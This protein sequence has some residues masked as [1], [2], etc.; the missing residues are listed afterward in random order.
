[1][2]IVDDIEK[3]TRRLVNAGIGAY[4]TVEEKFEGFKADVE[5]T[6][7]EWEKGFEDLVVKGAADDSDEARNIRSKLDE[8][9]TAVRKFQE[10]TS[11][12]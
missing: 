8:G 5:K 4:R 3:N 1:M 10:K 11:N 7:A 9:V 2:A 6:R 12:S